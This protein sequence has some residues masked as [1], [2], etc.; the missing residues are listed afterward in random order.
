MDANIRLGIDGLDLSGGVGGQR[1]PTVLL[2]GEVKLF[3]AGREALLAFAAAGLETGY[4]DICRLDSGLD[5]GRGLGSLG[6]LGS[7]GRLGLGLVGILPLGGL[8]PS[9]RFGLVL[10]AL[11]PAP[12]P[13]LG[14]VAQL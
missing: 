10:A 5:D 9:W 11:G 2:A 14:L 13:L 7:L 6:S 8:D 4:I 3:A 12:S 1:H